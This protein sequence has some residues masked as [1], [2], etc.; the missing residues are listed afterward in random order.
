MSKQ[1]LIIRHATAARPK[2]IH[3]DFDRPLTTKGQAEADGI[4]RFLKE[5]DIHPEFVLCSSAQRTAETFQ[6]INQHLNIAEEAVSYSKKI[7]EVF[8][9]DLFKIVSE[10]D[11]SYQRIALIGHN[12]GVSDLINYLLDENYISLPPAGTALLE[13]PFDDWKMLSKGLVQIKLLHYPED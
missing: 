7:Y 4:G 3:S 12:N 8:Y 6:I 5:Q 13:F 9:K 11:N 1:L 10:I 2:D